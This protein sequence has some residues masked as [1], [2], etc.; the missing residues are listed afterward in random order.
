MSNIRFTL[1]IAT[2][3]GLA[4]PAFAGAEADYLNAQKIGMAAVEQQIA[5][6]YKVRYSG[7]DVYAAT[8]SV[9]EARAMATGLCKIARRYMTFDAEHTLRVFLVSGD[10][11]AAT[12]IM[13]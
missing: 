10:R 6:S 2:S 12:C 7:L 3:I 1:A 13:G 4:T 8:N 9:S 5:V 11:P